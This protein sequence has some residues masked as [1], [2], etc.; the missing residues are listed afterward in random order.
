M[1]CQC[2]D[3]GISEDL[4]HDSMPLKSSLI[5]KCTRGMTAAVAKCLL[6]VPSWVVSWCGVFFR[7]RYIK[8]I[9][10][11]FISAY[12]YSETCIEFVYFHLCLCGT[13]PGFLCEFYV[14]NCLTQTGLL[15]DFEKPL[16][17]HN[18]P[19]RSK[20]TARHT[21]VPRHVRFM[22][23]D[24]VETQVSAQGVIF[25]KASISK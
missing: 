4:L 15:W 17:Q 23:S 7:R 20:P 22:N 19:R 21:Q 5:Y 6:F 25:F 13:F 14:Q 11:P 3:P 10:K 16:S 1:L 8:N 24:S 9:R 18:L 2:Y 12:Q